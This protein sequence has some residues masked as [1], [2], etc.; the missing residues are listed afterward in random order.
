MRVSI[1]TSL[2]QGHSLCLGE[3]PDVF[4]SNDEGGYS[5]V[6]V[7]VVPAPSEDGVRRA[8]MNCPERAITITED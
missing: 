5:E 3:A 2:C 8:A 7:D 4:E 6:V 1:D